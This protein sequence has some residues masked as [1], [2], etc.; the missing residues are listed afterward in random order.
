MLED[1]TIVLT[2]AAGILGKVITATLG[3][4]GATVIA[5]DRDASA[6]ESL[7][8]ELSAGASV[9]P[10][11]LDITSEAAVSDEI[12]RLWEDHGPIHGLVNNAASKGPELADF[13]L[14]FDESSLELWRAVN[15]VNLDGSYLMAREVG[16]RMA[17]NGAGSIVQIASIYGIR[18]PDHRIY[19]GSFYNGKP[20]AS[21]AVYSASKAGVLG[22]MAYVATLWGSEGVR[23][24][25]VTPGGV[26][27][28]QND[29]FISRYSAR[30]PMGRMANPEDIAN[31]I[32]FLLSDQAAYIN[33]HNLVVDGGLSAW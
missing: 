18:G 27:S 20:I 32:A 13:L 9:I 33:G 3:D 8:G 6:L 14:P 17:A 29:E 26:L 21:P 25:A 2:G 15:A 5:I 12:A 10:I 1:K 28:G 30:V 16:K 22:L 23:S 4:A 11:E 31:P 7:Q 19:E 24:N